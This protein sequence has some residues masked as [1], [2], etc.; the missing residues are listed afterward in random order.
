MGIKINPE[1][2]DSLHSKTDYSPDT[3]FSGNDGNPSNNY[4]KYRKNDA[5]ARYVQN[6]SRNQTPVT[7]DNAENS[8]YRQNDLW[9]FSYG[10]NNAQNSSYGQDN[11]QKDSYAQDDLWDFSYGQNDAKSSSYGQNNAQ[12]IPY[13]QGNTQY[14]SYRQNNAQ[15]SSCEQRNIQNSSGRNRNAQNHPRDPF[16]TAAPGSSGKPKNLKKIFFPILIAFISIFAL[17]GIYTVAKNLIFRNEPTVTESKRNPDGESRTTTGGKGKVSSGDEGH[18]LN[19][20]VWN[21]EF[22]YRMEDH[23]PGYE[24][25]SGTQGRIGDVTVNWI[26]TENMDN[27]YQI[28]L[29]KALAEQSS[30][31]ADK[32]IDMFLVETESARKYVDPYADAAMPLK[33]LG[34]TDA[35]LSKQFPYTQDVVRDANG[36]LR[37]SSWQACSGGMIYRRDIAQAVFGVS[38]PEDVQKLFKDWDAYKAAAA[39]LMKAGYKITSTVNDTYRVYSNN[40][41]GQWVQDGRIVVDDNIRKWADD[42]MELVKAGETDTF[43][44][45]SDDWMMGFYEDGNVFA[46]FG[47]LWFINFTMRSYDNGSVALDG[48]WA[49]TAGPQSFYW[50]GAWICAAQGTDNPTLVKDIILTLTADDAVMKDIAVKDS[51]CVNN[52]D[53]LKELSN[54]KGFGNVIL[55][56]QNPYGVL[57]ASAELID[58]SNISIYDLG[59][60]EQFQYTMLEYIEGRSTYRDALKEFERNVKTLYPEIT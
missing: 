47:P 15:N 19:I 35:D 22:I 55:G 30:A 50:G 58:M 17:I 28:N 41:S 6:G 52:R 4:S 33:D 56:G 46:Y 37:G 23:Y 38:E 40:V 12:N 21:E 27:A 20:E 48:G 29:D 34:I 25:I 54:D 16:G 18:V 32:K 45:W 26:I 9:N 13:G 1:A 39:R 8:S 2:D 51:D 11:T 57:A 53:V 24:K 14:S 36:D 43:D 3:Q 10:Q 31:V 42:S 59:C 49:L 60:Y 7:P 5:G 44:L